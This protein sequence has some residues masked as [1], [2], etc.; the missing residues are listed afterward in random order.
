MASGGQAVLSRDGKPLDADFAGLIRA[1]EA[2]ALLGPQ[3][4]LEQAGLI[5]V[6]RLDPESFTPPA[7]GST[8]RSLGFQLPEGTPAG[9]ITGIQRRLRRLAQRWRGPGAEPIT[10]TW[11]L[12]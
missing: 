7:S 3:P 8:G 12:A 6:A 1:E 11:Q 2:V 5:T 9:A 10:L 4:V